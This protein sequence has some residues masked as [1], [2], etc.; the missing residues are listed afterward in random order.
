MVISSPFEIMRINVRIHRERI[1]NTYYID[2]GM[3]LSNETCFFFLNTQ[4]LE[5]LYYLLQTIFDCHA[6]YLS[7]PPLWGHIQFIFKIS[8]LSHITYYFQ[9]IFAFILVTPVPQRASFNS[10]LLNELL[11]NSIEIFSLHGSLPY[12]PETKLSTPSCELL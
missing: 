6:T 2:N 7:S 5:T 10:L 3:I 9:N 11:L 1:S 4:S 12:I 8:L